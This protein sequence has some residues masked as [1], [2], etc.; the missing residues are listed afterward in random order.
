MSRLSIMHTAW[1][2]DQGER[3]GTESSMAKVFVSAEGGD[4]LDTFVG[5]TP[6]AVAMRAETVRFLD[7]A[8]APGTPTSAGLA[9]AL[10]PTGDP[11]LSVDVAPPPGT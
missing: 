2:L 11:T 4:H 8:L 3:G 7:A 9:A 6:A 1:T 10:T 5:A